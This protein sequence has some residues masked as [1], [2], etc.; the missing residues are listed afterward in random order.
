MSDDTSYQ[1]DALVEAEKI[2]SQ[3]AVLPI[4]APE[5]QFNSELDV[6]VSISQAIMSE[7]VS[8]VVN[9]ATVADGDIVH[10]MQEAES[11]FK[12]MMEIHKQLSK[13]F[14][15]LNN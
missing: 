7:Q 2:D 4:Q 12:T 1:V 6:T 13:A 14:L 8:G 10:A 9:I 15:D 3:I 5:I 11:S